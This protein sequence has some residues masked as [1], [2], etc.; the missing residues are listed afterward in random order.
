MEEKYFNL[1][2]K[3]KN[4]NE[5]NLRQFEDTQEKKLKNLINQTQQDMR[6]KNVDLKKKIEMK[7]QNIDESDRKLLNQ[8][9]EKRNRVLD[10]FEG[11]RK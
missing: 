2:E 9:E 5:E 11:T 7:K 3:V 1:E 4:E 8:I 6:Y 10:K